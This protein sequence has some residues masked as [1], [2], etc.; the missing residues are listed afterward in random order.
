MIKEKD[1]MNRLFINP[2]N[3]VGC[4]NEK[5]RKGDVGYRGDNMKPRKPVKMVRAMSF[6]DMIQDV[7]EKNRK[8][9]EEFKKNGGMCLHCGKEKGDQ[10]STLNPFN[11][12]KCNEET[13]K[14]LSQL[15]GPGF[16]H[17]KI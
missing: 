9:T 8:A 15:K 6:G 16:F 4:L 14:L 7:Q 10:T 3:I 1:G 5:I 12:K 2:I 13:Q 17:M 11:C